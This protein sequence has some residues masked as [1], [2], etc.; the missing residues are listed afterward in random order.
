MD[1]IEQA[2][3]VLADAEKRLRELVGSAAAAGEYD[4]AMRVAQWAKAVG[5]LSKNGVNPSA[6][7]DSQGLHD[8][9]RW[10]AI[11]QGT[12]SQARHPLPGSPAHARPHAAAGRQGRRIAAKGEY[13][14]FYRRGDQLVKIGW[15]K[16][17]RAEY[18]HKAPRRAVDLLADAIGKIGGNGN[19]FTS[20][21]V[22]PLRDPAD[23]TEVPGYQGYVALAWFK[24][25]GL[26][27]QNGRRGYSGKKGVSVTD[28]AAAMW[29]SLPEQDT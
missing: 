27:K 5:A 29:S 6:P 19:L 16:K 17:E 7:S 18:E 4:P 10:P 21:E 1:T 9:A 2:V 8:P 14:K 28:A 23:G 25:A 3:G 26:I 15:S 11:A 24:A 20:E 12:A 13:P 22:L